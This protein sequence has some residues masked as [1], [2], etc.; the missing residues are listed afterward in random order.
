MRC[1]V[2]VY[3]D[4]SLRHRVEKLQN[5]LTG[6][7]VKLIKPEN[8]HFTL[9]F[10]GE[11]DVNIRM[12]TETALEQLAAETSPFDITVEKIGAFPGVVWIG[13]PRLLNLHNTIDGGK[14][15]FEPVPHMTI[16]RGCDNLADF[17]DKNRD[18]VIGDMRVDCIKLKKSVLTPKGSVYSDVRIF[19]LIG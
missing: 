1:F 17:M 11:V 9:K 10:L 16:A 12:K 15:D 14:G 13:A 7:D 19:E 5:E 2:A 4:P 8:L 3:L 6:L 18:I